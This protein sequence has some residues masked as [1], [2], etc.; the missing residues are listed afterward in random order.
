M[1]DT[2]CHVVFGVDDGAHNIDE[3][4]SMIQVAI[5]HGITAILCTPHSIPG[6]RF[7]RNTFEYLNSNFE[8]LKAK[9]EAL[10]LPIEIYLGSEFQVSD[11]ALPWITEHKI[12][13]LNHT[14]RVLVE[15][16]WHYAG[17]TSYSEEYYLQALIDAGY[18][19][20]V[21]HP[22]RYESVQKDF[23]TL[24]RWR[25]MGCAFQVNRTSLIQFGEAAYVQDVAW[26]MVKE[27]YC[28]VIASDAH[29]YIGMRINAL[30]DIYEILEKK[31]SPEVARKLCIDNPNRSITGEDY[32]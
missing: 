24:K 21:A 16:P 1:I 20:I 14:N 22:E 31:I 5:K 7:E 23:T 29:S 10:K 30:D 18:R 2:H 27:G 4:L 19:V 13:T 26:R 9:V 3:S 28:D 32:K 11:T 12:V 15:L 6:H 25:E 17:K 8:V